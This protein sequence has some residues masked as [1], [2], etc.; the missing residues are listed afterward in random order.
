MARGIPPCAR[1]DKPLGSSAWQGRS[2]DVFSWRMGGRCPQAVF[3]VSAS[4]FGLSC[5]PFSPCSAWESRGASS[6]CLCSGM[7]PCRLHFL[8][9]EWPGGQGL[10]GERKLLWELI[11]EARLP[12]RQ[13]LCWGI[14]C[15]PADLHGNGTFAG[16][17][18]VHLSWLSWRA[19]CALLL[20][21]FQADVVVYED[22][23]FFFI[24]EEVS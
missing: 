1:A 3:A 18:I 5:L 10:P 15:S 6:F 2:L 4:S 7:W 23:F 17:A 14:Y 21:A 20:K 11:A 9:A 19:A 16:S 24:L 22:F 12:G 8:A 13:G